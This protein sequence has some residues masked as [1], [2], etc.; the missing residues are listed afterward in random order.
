LEI[1]GDVRFE[2]NIKIKGRVTLINEKDSQAVVREG[3]VREGD[4]V[5]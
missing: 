4:L 5:L 3:T 2:A 1:I